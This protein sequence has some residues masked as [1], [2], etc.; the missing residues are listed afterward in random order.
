MEGGREGGAEGADQGRLKPLFVF[1]V[2]H[3]ESDPAERGAHP[4]IEQPEV[5]GL[6]SQF[7]HIIGTQAPNQYPASHFTR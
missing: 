2:E 1:Q 3:G 6:E 5:V 4:G 7:R